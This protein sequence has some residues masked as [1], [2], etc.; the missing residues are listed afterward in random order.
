MKPITSDRD[1]GRDSPST[2]AVVVPRGNAARRACV[3]WL[4]GVGE[5]GWGGGG[6]GGRARRPGEGRGEGEEDGRVMQR[7]GGRGAQAGSG[8]RAEA[9]RRRQGRGACGG[10]GSEAH[11][12]PPCPP[13]LLQVRHRQRAPLAVLPPE[14]TVAACSLLTSSQSPFLCLPC[15]PPPLTT[16]SQQIT[17]SAHL[18]ASAQS[19]ERSSEAGELSSERTSSP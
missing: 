14:K 6:R 2:L 16:R 12:T 19:F 11:P 15:C 5:G 10:C 7:D 1:T 18:L 17:T 9:E 3:R 8:A 13:C 4:R